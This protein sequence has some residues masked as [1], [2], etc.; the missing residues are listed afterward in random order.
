M[1]FDGLNPAHFQH[2]SRHP[3]RT[4]P[5]DDALGGF[6]E[7]N[8]GLDAATGLDEARRC[9]ACGVCNECELCRIFCPDVAI[10]PRDGHGFRIDLEY[11][12]GCGVCVAEC[13]RG[14]MVLTREGLS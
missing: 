12:K 13:P 3:D 10:S 7:V 6:T 8:I 5:L 14:A 11:C 9:F 1:T 2:A 4:A